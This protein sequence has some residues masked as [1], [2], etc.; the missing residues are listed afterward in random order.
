MKQFNNIFEVLEYY[1]SDERCRDT[2]EKMR[3]PDG[4]IICPKCKIDY[5]YRMSDMRNYKCRDKKCGITFSVTQGTIYEATKLHLSKWFA[6]L[7]LLTAHKKGISSCQ[8]ARDL[9][10]EQKAAWFLL[11]RLRVMLRSRSVEKL[12]NIVEIDETYVGGKWE[13][14]NKDKRAKCE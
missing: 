7:Y 8:L 13:N 10:I 1:K 9:G 11:T 6:A 14:M 5:C 2:I 4:N 12:D 3:W